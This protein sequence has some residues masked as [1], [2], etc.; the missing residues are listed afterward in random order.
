MS[1]DTKYNATGANFNDG[2]NI[3]WTNPTNF[4]GDTTSTAATVSPASAGHV[5]QQ[6]QATAFG[7]AI[8]TDA[9]INGI[10]AQ[11]ESAA[12]NNNRHAWH[13]VQLLKAGS[14]VGSNL[15]DSAVIF[16]KAFKQFGD[17]ATLW[18]TTWTPSEINASG[19]G[20]LVKITRTGTATTTS[21][22]RVYINVTYTPVGSNQ[23]VTMGIM[24]I[25]GGLM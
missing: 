7:F 13:T 16:S 15:S 12:A 2:G 5:S 6:L 22:Y 10:E 23:P 19:F 17:A 14:A 18:G 4:A 20:V 21:M 8:P 9:T 1:A 11:I 25:V 3:A 24:Q